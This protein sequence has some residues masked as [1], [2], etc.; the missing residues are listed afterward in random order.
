MSRHVTFMTIDAAGHYSQE[1]TAIVV[2]YAGH[3]R[4]AHIGWTSRRRR[5]PFRNLDLFVCCPGH[6]VLVAPIAYEAAN[7]WRLMGSRIWREP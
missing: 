1:R 5:S 6:V 7:D 4:E 2:A 3:E